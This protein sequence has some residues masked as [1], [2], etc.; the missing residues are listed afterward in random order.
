MA[1]TMKAAVVTAHHT[2]ELR[3]VPLPRYGNYQALVKLTYGSTCAGTDLRVIAGGHPHPLAF[4]AILGHESVGRVLEKGRN[5]TTFKEGDLIARVGASP[6]PDIGL[7]VCWGGFA[8]YGVATDWQAMRRDG[9]PQSEWDKARVQQ[10][11]PAGIDDKTGPMMITWRETLSYIQRI[12]V[13]AGDRVLITGSG[14]NALAFL[15]HSVYAGAQAV[16]LGS[17]RRADDMLRLGA[18]H[19]IDYKS[20]DIPAQLTDALPGG[21]DVIID[22]VGFA[23]N[24]NAALPLLNAGGVVGVYGWHDRAGYGINPFDARRS[25]RVYCD[26]Y[27]EAETHDEVIRRVLAH[28]LSAADWYDTQNPVLLADIV[29]AYDRLKKGADVYKY[30]IDLT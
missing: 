28:K 19:A 7:G 12:G 5:V 9:I 26:G 15:A 16:V 6:M 23:Q 22:A 3:D 29:D 21:I 8:Q 4:P 20:G 18:A 17:G 24:V 2:L 14:A 1:D 13:K 30:L 10:V 11:I 27:D 25:F